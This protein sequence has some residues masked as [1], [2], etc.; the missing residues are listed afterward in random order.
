[1]VINFVSRIYYNYEFDFSTSIILAYI[2]GMFVA[3]I[4]GKCFVFRDSK[5]PL[6]RS[7]LFFI[8]INSMGLLQTWI[9]SL[10]LAHTVLPALSIKTYPLEIAHAIGLAFPAFSTFLGHKYFT[11]RTH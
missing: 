8:L 5:Q 1:M 4:L 7:I 10:F 11:F 9:I 3:F 2:T 6:L